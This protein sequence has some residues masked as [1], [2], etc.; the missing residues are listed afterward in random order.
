MSEDA[1]EINTQS[2]FSMPHSR[3]RWPV[4]TFLIDRGKQMIAKHL[5]V[6]VI[7]RAFQAAAVTLGFCLA[8][9]PVMSADGIDPDVDKVLR[10]MS[11]YLD[12]LSA[13]SMNADIDDEIVT[14]DGQKLQ[15]SSAANFVIVRP[16]KLYAHRHGAF[17]EAEFIF[18][19][20]I[21]T[22]YGKS[23][24]AYVQIEGPKTIDEATRAIGFE[25]GLDMPAAELLDADPYTGLVSNVLS[26]DYL[27]T[28]YVNGVECHYLTFRAAQVDWQLWV[29]TGD[30]PLPMKYVITSKW[31]TGAPQYSIRFRDWDT[32]PQI[33][34]E[35]FSFSAP[36]GARKLETIPV[37]ALGEIMPEETK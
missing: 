22:L 10:S 17:A 1:C 32:A 2:Y 25:L 5:T 19:G 8:A 27:G 3:D 12:G 24:N 28:V 31:V 30:E 14:L 9:S 6:L 18:D 35:Q 36:K 4:F 11:S 15:F 16:G 26:S 29:K 13:F 37:N 21:L 34:A 20:K 7:R 33:E 23:G